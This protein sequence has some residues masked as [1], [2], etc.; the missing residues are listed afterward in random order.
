MALLQVHPAIISLYFLE[1][2]PDPNQRSMVLNL[3]GIQ[4]NK[5]LA[6]NAGKQ[7]QQVDLASQAAYEGSI[8]FARSRFLNFYSWLPHY[9]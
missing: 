7:F 4:N 6:G 3:V 9:C 2:N 1:M 5:A 8:P